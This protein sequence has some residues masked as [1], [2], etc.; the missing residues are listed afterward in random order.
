MAPNQ[1]AHRWFVAAA[2]A[3]VAHALPSL[4]WALGGTALVSTLGG[5]AADWQRKA[6]MQVLV[7]LLVIFAVKLAGAFVP[8]A[9]ERGRLP[10]PRL[11]RGLSWAG[12]GVLVAYGAV[13]VVAA[14]AA[15][16]GVVAAGPTMD[17]AALVGHA[18]LWDP[19]FL[20][21]GLLLATGLWRSRYQKTGGR[22]RAHLV[23]A[24]PSAR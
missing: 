23:A 18:F 2:V 1:D 8:L 17:T 10:A 24:A 21:W 16:T 11:W 13:N 4:Y 15:L 14:L 19:L 7:L 12:A 6:P 9:N 5:W 3:G 20:V 22:D